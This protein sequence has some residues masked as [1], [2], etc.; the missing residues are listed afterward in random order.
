MQNVLL[1]ILHLMPSILFVFCCSFV[2][3]GA[4]SAEDPH[5][6]VRYNHPL[7]QSCSCIVFQMFPIPVSVWRSWAFQQDRTLRSIFIINSALNFLGHVCVECASARPSKFSSSHSLSLS[8]SL[9]L[10]LSCFCFRLFAEDPSLDPAIVPF[11]A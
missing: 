8:L 9:P 2:L 7:C 10:Y 3:G 6:L 4:C 5:L 1:L 11:K